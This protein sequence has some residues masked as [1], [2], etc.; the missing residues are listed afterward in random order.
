MSASDEFFDYSGST[1][2]RNGSQRSR[3]F[4]PLIGEFDM[5]STSE[6]Q[7]HS[8]NSVDPR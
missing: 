8:R 2:T 4:C 7:S 5:R 3:R 6:A 1:V